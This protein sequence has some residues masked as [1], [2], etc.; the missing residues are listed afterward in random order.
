MYI[1]KDSVFH[2]QY[3]MAVF[4]LMTGTWHFNLSRPDEYEKLLL[5]F[6]WITSS[7]G[8]YIFLF[9]FPDKF[10]FIIFYLLFQVLYKHK[11]IIFG[12]FYDTLREVR[13]VTD[14]ITRFESIVEYNLGF[15]IIMQAILHAYSTV[16]TWS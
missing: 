14:S 15:S 3:F 2:F 13:L 12:G 16:Y 8:I 6:I 4:I 9:F 1:S 7:Y 5:W 10:V 11:L